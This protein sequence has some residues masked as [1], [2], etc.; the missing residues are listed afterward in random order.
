MIRSLTVN[1][2]A[3]VPAVEERGI[4]A[5][6]IVSNELRDAVM[7]ASLGKHVDR[8]VTAEVCCERCAA[9]PMGNLGCTVGRIDA[10]K[11]VTRRS[12]T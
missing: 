9:E 10:S 4:Q 2:Q 3:F 11:N 7:P 1:S 12:Q 5:F 6:G 8:R